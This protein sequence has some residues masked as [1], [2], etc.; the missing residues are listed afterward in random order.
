M[1]LAAHV[2]PAGFT[3]GA[4]AQG[5]TG[6][7]ELDVLEVLELVLPEPPDDEVVELDVLDEL[8]EPGSHAADFSSSQPA[9]SMHF[10]CVSVKRPQMS[11]Q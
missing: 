6:P 1:Q 2:E 3:L 11:L 7:P 5:M 8:V 10:S 4:P 9:A